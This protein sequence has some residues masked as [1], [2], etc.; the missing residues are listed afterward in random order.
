MRAALRTAAR[1]PL[2]P[3]RPPPPL[4][5]CIIHLPVRGCSG[6]WLQRRCRS[7]DAARWPHVPTPAGMKEDLKRAKEAGGAYDPRNAGTAWSH[8]FL[9]QVHVMDYYVCASGQQHWQE[10]GAKPVSPSRTG[11]CHRYSQNARSPPLPLQKPW[12]PGNFRNQV[13]KY[14]AEQRS[15]AEK[16]AKEQ[17]L[18]SAA[19]C[20]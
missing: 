6:E 20:G 4:L 14:D 1:R 17:G 8:N 9:N 12:H 10:A 18:V 2:L 19:G 5:P 11:C 13:K 7:P 15:I 16:K 3:H